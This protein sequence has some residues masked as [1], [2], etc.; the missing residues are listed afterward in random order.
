MTP[1]GRVKGKV[2]KML[3]VFGTGIY[4]FMP[5]QAGF[6]S[7]SLDY[8]L[9]VN[10]RFISIE[11]KAPGK[12]LTPLQESTKAAM[13]AA[14]GVVLIVSDDA[15]LEAARQRIEWIIGHGRREEALNLNRAP[16]GEGQDQ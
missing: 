3:D 13:E 1:E 8:L 10:T 4:R 16:Q 9:C 6:G 2:K 5:V 14:G 11:T 12:R 7:V 15:S